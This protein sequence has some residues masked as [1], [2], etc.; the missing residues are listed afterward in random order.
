MSGPD[1]LLQKRSASLPSADILRQALASESELITYQPHGSGQ[2][3]K[4]DRTLSITRF[5]PSS[6]KL[7]KMGNDRISR[8]TFSVTLSDPTIRAPAAKPG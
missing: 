7:G 4:N 1:G 3:Q 5:C 8:V 2:R 6:G